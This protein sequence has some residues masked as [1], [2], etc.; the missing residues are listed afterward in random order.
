M[1]RLLGVAAAVF[2]ASGPVLAQ[3][4]LELFAT[5]DA[6]E[7][8][9][10]QI[11]RL[12]AEGG[13]T[14]PGTIDPLRALAFQYQEA[15]NDTLAIVALE[16]ARH[17]TRVHQGLT[18]AD[19]ALLLQQ[20]I[21][22]EQA[23]GRHERVWDLE[24]DMVTIARQHLDDM[25]MVPIFS[26]LAE[27]RSEVL[28]QYRAGSLPPEIT[29]GCYHA[30][31]RP[32][33]DDTRGKRVP[34]IGAHGGCG[35]GQSSTVV[36]QLHRE[37]L[38]YYADAIEVLV[39]NGDYASRELRD[40]ERQALRVGTP[41]WRPHRIMQAT[42]VV[43]TMGN[44]AAERGPPPSPTARCR[45]Q[46]LD[47]MLAL[48]LLGTC[49]QPVIRGPGFVVSNVGGWVGHIRLIAYEMRSGAPAA[50]RANAIAE[51]ADWQLVTTPAD[52][53]RFGNGDRAIGLYERAYRE[54]Q[55]ARDVQ[56]ST[57]QIFAPELPVTLPTYEPNPFAAASRA[58]SSRYI[59]VVFAVTKYGMG[60]AIEIRD[61]S[62]GATRAEE[63]DLLR[64]IERATFRPRV[65]DNA[66]ADSASVA[67]RYHLRP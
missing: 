8:L 31:P 9:V 55:R 41:S 59:D 16:E 48:P 50:D 17:V 26:E 67:L 20:Q 34:P 2:L 57:A 44:G 33:Y 19:E 62:K 27:D 23:L 3:P 52:R 4:E 37:I 21:R 25:R 10:E 56:T 61:T 6:Q 38:G 60:E 7:E 54:L 51:L 46:S 18:A 45:T 14:P 29:L 1:N 42:G 64:L 63:R 24:Q 40:L 58:G 66:L 43:P 5:T 39:R 12:R 13:P 22:S 15:G 11:A 65:V 35:S 36:S 32:R 28:E 30:A 53:R 49:L 47:G